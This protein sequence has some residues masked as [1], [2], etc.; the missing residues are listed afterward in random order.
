[1]KNSTKIILIVSAALFFAGIVMVCVFCAL[2]GSFD[3]QGLQEKTHSVYGTV[4]DVKVTLRGTDFLL[5]PSPDGTVYAR[6]KEAE[7]ITFTVENKDGTLSVTE[8]DNRKWYEFIGISL[9][10]QTVTLYLPAG[11]YGNLTVET[12]AGRIKCWESFIFEN[13]VLTASSGSVECYAA[14]KRTLQAETSSGKIE[15][16][17]AD[18]DKVLLTASSGRIILSDSEPSLAELTSSSGSINLRDVTCSTLIAAATSGRI[19]LD[20]TVAQNSLWAKTTSGAIQL[21]R[22]DASSLDLEATSGLISATL[23]TGKVYNVSTGSGSAKYPASDLDGG[24][25][26]VTTTSGSVKITVSP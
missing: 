11:E 19:S 1:M 6:C 22:C 7:N 4:T 13:A 25:C 8:N 9:Q 10:P 16:K 23:L 2:G 21:Q 3:T 20:R 5:E 12:S 24:V 18:A 14:V 26:N 15:V 17:N